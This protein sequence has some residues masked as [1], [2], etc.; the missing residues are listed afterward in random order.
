MKLGKYLAVFP[1]KFV[2]YNNGMFIMFLKISPYALE[3]HNGSTCRG[4]QH[5]VF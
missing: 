3:I 1:I 2:T 5:Y 4:K